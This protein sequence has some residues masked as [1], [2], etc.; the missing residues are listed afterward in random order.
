MI[1]RWPAALLSLFIATGTWAANSTCQFE[2]MPVGPQKMGAWI[3]KS[4][5]LAIESQRVRWQ[6]SEVLMPS[7]RTPPSGV[8]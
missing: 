5:W 8:R 1:R 6:A 4:N 3:D 2:Q 7:W